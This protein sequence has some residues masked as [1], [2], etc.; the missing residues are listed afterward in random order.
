MAGCNAPWRSNC[1]KSEFSPKVGIL[2]IWPLNVTFGSKIKPT[3]VI[4]MMTH[5]IPPFT[6]IF[7]KPIMNA[8][9]I[10]D[11]ITGN[12]VKSPNLTGKPAWLPTTK[13]TPFAAI[14]SKNK[15]IPI[16]APCAILN[17]RLRKIHE[18]IPV[19]EIKVNTKPI[20]NTAPNATGIETP[21]PMTKLNAVKAVNEMAHPIAIGA[22]A[23]KPIKIEPSPATK[24][25]AINTDSAGKPA[26][27]SILGTTI[28]E[29]TMAK[30]VVKPAMIS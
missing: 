25:V 13:P 14:K 5:K 23:Q 3:I 30:K 10:K 19:A 11:I 16:P 26:S 21:C 22:F 20:R 6:F 15:P 7:S 24:Q 18:R 4:A 27:P 1:K 17:G 9:P 28:T 29:Y 8:R 2:K 12:E